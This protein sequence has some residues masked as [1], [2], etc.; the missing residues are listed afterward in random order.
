[1]LLRQQQDWSEHMVK[2]AGDYVWYVMFYWTW[3]VKIIHENMKLTKF[4]ETS[5]ANIIIT[6][7][8]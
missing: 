1:M 7:D 8:T 6:M 3:P 5:L 4:A 2:V